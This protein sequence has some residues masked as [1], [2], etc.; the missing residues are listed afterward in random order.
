VRHADYVG[1]WISVLRDDDHAIVRAASQASKAADY[2]L[3][4]LPA[5]DTVD[6]AAPACDREAA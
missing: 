5:D 1:S 2:L 4:F 6:L 3:A